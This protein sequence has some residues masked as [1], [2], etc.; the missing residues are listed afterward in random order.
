MFS[1]E[2]KFNLNNNNNPK[3]IKETL[4]QDLQKKTFSE[5]HFA[6]FQTKETPLRGAE[7]PKQTRGEAFRFERGQIFKAYKILRQQIT[8]A[9]ERG[10]ETKDQKELLDK[11]GSQAE[12][13]EKNLDELERQYYE[14]GKIVEI[15]TEFGHFSVPVVELDLRSKE[16]RESKEEAPT[17]YFVLGSVAQNYHQ[18]AAF[19]MGLALSGERVIVP[20]WPNQ[21][22][23]RPDNYG[24]LLNKQ[25]DLSIQKEY[26][27][28]TIQALGLEKINLIGYSMGAAVSLEVAQDESCPQIQDLI[29]V[30]PAGLEDK[31]FLKL[32]KD[33]AFE[34][35][36]LKTMPFSENRIKTVNQGKREEVLDAGLLLEDCKIL[37]KKC[38]DEKKLAKIM[39]KGRY[40]LWM[41]TKSSIVDSKIAEKIFHDAEKIRKEKN[42]DASPLEINVINGGT[43]GWPLVHNFGFS[44]MVNEAERPGNEVNNIELSD[45]ENSLIA[46]ILKEMD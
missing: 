31:G 24:K 15:D 2:S 3:N 42:P 44:R 20:S 9:K 7:D 23:S 11:V 46:K 26:I 27:K 5:K 12:I 45:L 16:R 35:G 13:W 1:P 18:M 37:S 43:H 28:K 30:E 33:F 38:F 22:A 17:P 21:A 14:N 29:I 25:G 40:Q 36:M 32:A 4:E 34:E 39:P 19:S 10:A 6:E 8:E 41:G